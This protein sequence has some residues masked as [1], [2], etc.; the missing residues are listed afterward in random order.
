MRNFRDRLLSYYSVPH[1]ASFLLYIIFVWGIA[2]ARRDYLWINGDD[3]NLLQQSML[4][5]VGFIPNVDY[6]SG[7]PGLSL[8]LQS[9]LIRLVGGIPLSQHLYTAFQATVLGGV[10]FWAGKRVAPLLLLLILLFVYSQSILHNPTPNPG[11]LFESLFI[12]GLKKTWDY[13]E[14]CQTKSAAFAGVAFGIA[15]LAKQYGIFGPI[16]FFLS[17]LGLLNVAPHWRRRLFGL[18]LVTTVCAI[19]YSYFGGFVINSAYSSSGAILTPD[20]SRLLLLNNAAICVI[21]VLVG[22][23]AYLVM[24]QKADAR[25]LS[26]RDFIISNIV[27]FS[28]FFFVSMGYLFL[29]YGSAVL[30]VL[31]EIMIL[32]PK[33][34]NSYLVEISFSW[35]ALLRMAYGL[36]TLAVLVYILF[37]KANSRQNNAYMFAIVLLGF[38]IYRGANLSATPFLSLSYVIVVVAIIGQLNGPVG[39]RMVVVMASISPFFVILIPYPNFSYHFP[40]LLF[41]YFLAPYGHSIDLHSQG[42]LNG[43]GLAPYIILAVFMGAVVFKA[44]RDISSYEKYVFNGVS[45]VSGDARWHEAIDE[46]NTVQRDEGRCS[47]YGCRYLLLTNPSFTDYGLIIEKPTFKN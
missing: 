44:S 9:L 12:I 18:C 31:H 22:L 16:C 33:R 23:V 20:E 39:M 3:P 28:V 42:R 2:Y 38:L 17:T 37:A 34:I 30:D 21:P 36:L 45:F 47:T 11:Y 10:F 27:V 8:Y 46:A 25:R 41:I 35:V 7:Y 4:I 24:D 14:G 5:N 40:L 43:I 19:L 29:L 15:F 13:L 32:A 1:M 26:L 6:F